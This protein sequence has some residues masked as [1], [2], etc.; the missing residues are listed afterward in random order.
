MEDFEIGKVL[1]IKGDQEML[2]LARKKTEEALK[3]GL[4]E[5]TNAVIVTIREITRKRL[6]PYT[7]KK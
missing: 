7:E 6:A 5:G 1:Y 3:S 4:Q 2:Y